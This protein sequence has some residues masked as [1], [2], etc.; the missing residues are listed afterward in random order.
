MKRLQARLKNVNDLID[1]ATL[2][3]C[4]LRKT[5]SGGIRHSRTHLLCA[6]GRQ[7]IGT[8]RASMDLSNKTV[9][10]IGQSSGSC[11]AND[12]TTEVHY[13]QRSEATY[14]GHTNAIVRKHVNVTLS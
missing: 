13:R 11:P 7:S 5:S 3:V 4:Q 1:M 8:R 6:A 9:Q 14:I 12:P 2:Q 10:W